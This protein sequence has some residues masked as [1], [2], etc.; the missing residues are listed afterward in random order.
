MKSPAVGDDD[1]ELVVG[2]AVGEFDGV[3]D[4]ESV[5]GLL[6][7]RSEGDLEGA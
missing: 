5:V 3:L 6:E 7:G 1:G 4:G 2:L